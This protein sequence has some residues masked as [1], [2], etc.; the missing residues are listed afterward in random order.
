MHLD[1]AG[2]TM[3]H[4]VAFIIDN[5]KRYALPWISTGRWVSLGGLEINNRDRA[6]SL[7][8]AIDTNRGTPELFTASRQGR[9]PTARSRTWGVEE[10]P[11]PLKSLIS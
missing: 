8:L 9:P 11:G 6:V 4:P 3:R 10:A 5:A 7:R 1:L 2:L